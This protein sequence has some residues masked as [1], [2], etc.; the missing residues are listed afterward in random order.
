MRGC[1]PSKHEFVLIHS[2]LFSARSKT[3]TSEAEKD[4]LTE[5]WRTAHDLCSVAALDSAFEDCRDDD[6]TYDLGS[7]SIFLTF[8]LRVEYCALI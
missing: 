3:T 8:V 2:F 4:A 5:Q 6:M 1:I 7:W